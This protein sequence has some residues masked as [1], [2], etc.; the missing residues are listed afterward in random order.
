[1]AQEIKKYLKL[2]RG[3]AQNVKNLLIVFILIMYLIE[4]EKQT[5]LHSKQKRKIQGEVEYRF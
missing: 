2:L 1:M 4:G 5:F 3:E